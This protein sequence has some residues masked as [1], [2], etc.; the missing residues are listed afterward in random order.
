[1]RTRK[2]LLVL[3]ALLLCTNLF[4]QLGGTHDYLDTAYISPTKMNQ[5]K[6]FVNNKSSF[7]SKPR[8]MWQ[9]GF[10]FGYPYI[11]GDCPTALKGKGNDIGSWTHGFGVHVRKSMGYVVSIRASF[12]YYNMIGLDYQPNGNV[13]NSPVIRALYV[14][15]QRYVHNYRSRA[16]AP[17]MEALLSFNNIMF[18]TKQQR[19]NL[20]GVI[21][22]TALVYSTRM[23]VRNT[24][25]SKYDFD[26]VTRGYNQGVPRPQI[27]QGLRDLMNGSYETPADVNDRRPKL[28]GWN[29]RHCFSSGFGIEYRMGKTWSMNFEYKRIQ[30]R[31]DYVD[32]WYRQSGDLDHPTFTSEWDNIGFFQ[33]GANFNVGNSKTKTPPLWWLNPLEFA[34]SDLS[35]SRNAIATKFKLK[36]DDGDGVINEMDL[37]PNTPE[38]CPVDTHGVT[39]DTDGDGVPD[40]KDKEKL[41][42]QKCFP[43]DADGV[44]NC[45][46]PPCCSQKDTI[47]VP[48]GCGMDALPSVQFKSPTKVQLSKDAEAI[49]TV[50]AEKIRKNPNCNVRITGYG[51]VD[52]KSQQLSWERV[53]AVIKYLVE[54]QGLSESRFIFKYGV[55]GDP[56]T[57]DLEGTTDVGVNTVPAPH[58][59]FRSR[60]KK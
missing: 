18:H 52:K 22:Y 5:Q 42:Q 34:Y 44:G 48:A 54:K 27:R 25:G 11:D 31:D 50:A 47:V 6:D 19:W 39:A 8:D 46:D 32:G 26:Q 4:A 7:P 12:A 51:D 23:D 28:F 9:A 20:Y 45:P 59:Q 53:N 56:Q 30:T 33:L 13:N 3:A 55:D 21:G 35:K 37:E 16:F 17:S 1:M 29:L 40:C 2:T 10:F 14:T 41:T 60:K 38:G 43:V 24:D 15:P 49:L 57:V 36:D 58:P